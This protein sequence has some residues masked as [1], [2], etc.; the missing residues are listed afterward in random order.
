MNGQSNHSAARALAPSA[1]TSRPAGC[2]WAGA[3]EATTRPGRQELPGALPR[4]GG[5]VPL[6]CAVWND[7]T[8]GWGLQSPGSACSSRKRGGWSTG[9]GGHAGELRDRALQR[10]A[11]RGAQ[12]STRRR[13]TDASRPGRSPRSGGAGGAHRR[14]RRGGRRERRRGPLETGGSSCSVRIRSSGSPIAMEDEPVP[15]LML[16]NAV[17]WQLAESG[18]S[19]RPEVELYSVA[20]PAKRRRMIPRVRG[21]RRPDPRR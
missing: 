17:D 1:S 11:L 8:E 12:P 5:A 10:A 9:D 21:P 19:E 4:K 20:A 14:R 16:R 18:A 7:G 13:R 6:R 2:T 3:P 15:G